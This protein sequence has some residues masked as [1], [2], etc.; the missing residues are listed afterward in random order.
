MAE[1]TRRGKVEEGGRTDVGRDPETW[2]LVTVS[3]R[4]RAA[5]D[6]LAAHWMGEGV[7][8]AHATA[9]PVLSPVHI[10]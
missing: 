9:T 8:E 3:G 2:R 4:L 10:V 7:G 6:C 1:S 5:V